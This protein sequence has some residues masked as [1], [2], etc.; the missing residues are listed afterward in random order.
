MQSSI[1]SLRESV[2]DLIGLP[3]ASPTPAVEIVERQ[4]CDGYVRSL[5]HYSAPDGDPIAA[6]LFDPID[7]SPH[8]DVVALHQH[9]SQWTI[10]KSEVAG[11]SGDPFQAFAPALA[12][13]GVRVLAPDAIGFESRFQSSGAGAELA[14]MLTRPGG[15]AEGWLQYYNQMAHRLVLGDLL[16]RKLL[17]DSRAAVSVLVGAGQTAGRPI[18]VLGHSL[19]GVL[20]LFLA[21]FDTR[22]AFACASGA[23]CSFR[24]KLSH[25]TGLDMS[26]VIPGIV[27]RFDIDDLIRCVAPRRLLVVSSDADPLS[28]DAAEL[29]RNAR[30]AFESNGCPDRL[31]HRRFEG[32][33]ALDQERFEAIV[34]WTASAFRTAV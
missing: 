18:G 15:T 21:A 20:S 34:D 33:H 22:L 4:S 24:H 1:D 11:L 3:P 6:F 13:R 2:A 17:L 16:M 5:L 25:G 7:G 27:R 28:A 14:P 9:N 26:L 32:A 29:V 30:P 19:G 10:G 23:V 12:R 31:E 8:A